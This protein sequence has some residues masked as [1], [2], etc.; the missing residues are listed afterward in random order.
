MLDRI[1]VTS[2]I[3]DGLSDGAEDVLKATHHPDGVPQYERGAI[4]V[5]PQPGGVAP[6]RP[7]LHRGDWMDDGLGNI[8]T[9]VTALLHEDDEVE[10]GVEDGD[11]DVNY[12]ESASTPYLWHEYEAV[13]GMHHIA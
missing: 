12:D 11:G 3:A 2:R 6:T 1:E 5:H 4:D 8:W 7:F 10:D 9:V 13:L